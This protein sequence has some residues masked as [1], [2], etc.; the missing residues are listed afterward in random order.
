MHQS[1]WHLPPRKSL[2]QNWLDGG[3]A[4]VPMSGVMKRL[5]SKED[6]GLPPDETGQMC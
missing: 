5:S 3:Q 6:D 4:R 1:P 2:L